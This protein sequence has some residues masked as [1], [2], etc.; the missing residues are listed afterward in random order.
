MLIGSFFSWWYGRGWKQTASSLG[1]RL[2]QVSIN[3]SVEQLLRTLFEPW[4]R[5]VTYSG[6]SL[7]AR[8]RAWGD[9]LFS[10]CVGFVVRSLVLFAA[11]LSSIIV[12][13][14]TLAEIL[15]WPLL[16][17]AVPLLLILGVLA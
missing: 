2:E 13:L 11:F 9:N 7:D 12:G 10:R 14:L 6:A 3:F 16:P 8:L 17:P 1:P 4:R 15:I 5:I